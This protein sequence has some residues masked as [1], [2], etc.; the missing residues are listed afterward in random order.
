MFDM[1]KMYDEF[2]KIQGMTLKTVSIMKMMN[3]EIRTETVVTSVDKAS[4]PA[5]TFEVPA[6]YKQVPSNM[7]K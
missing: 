6:G 5:S 7:T 4:I 3:M 1:S 2:K